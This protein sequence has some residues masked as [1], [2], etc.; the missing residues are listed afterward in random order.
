MFYKMLADEKWTLYLKEVEK[1][2]ENVSDEAYRAGVKDAYYELS[3]R[4]DL[5]SKLH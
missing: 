3:G 2:L 4:Y 5:V 1:S